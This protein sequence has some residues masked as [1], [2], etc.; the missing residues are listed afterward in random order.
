MV[1]TSP[2]N[3]GGAGSIPGQGANIPQASGPKKTEQKNNRSN[4]VTNSTKT[5]GQMFCSLHNKMK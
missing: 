5:V 1:K 2:S 3:T 4:T